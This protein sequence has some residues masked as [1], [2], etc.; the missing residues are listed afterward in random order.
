M[1][2]ASK[3]LGKKEP[4]VQRKRSKKSDV[5][6]YDTFLYNTNSDEEEVKFNLGLVNKVQLDSSYGYDYNSDY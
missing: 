5:A 6:D 3:V 2:S 4:K 1:K